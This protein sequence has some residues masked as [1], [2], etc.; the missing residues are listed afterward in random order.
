M[1]NRPCFHCRAV[2][3]AKQILSGHSNHDL[4]M[5]RTRLLMEPYS[6]CARVSIGHAFTLNRAYSRLFVN[7]GI[8]PWIGMLVGG[9]FRQRL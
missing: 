9:L 8:S 5:G 4:F 3:N 2:R 7:F 1:D 6:G